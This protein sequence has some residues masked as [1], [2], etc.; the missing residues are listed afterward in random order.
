MTYTVKYKRW[1]FWRTLKG[2]RGDGLVENNK[3]RFFVLDDESRVEVPVSAVFWFSKER[4]IS[5][6]KK[7]ESEAGQPIITK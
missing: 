7:M 6:K 2:V 3:A 4:Y 5:I 1:F